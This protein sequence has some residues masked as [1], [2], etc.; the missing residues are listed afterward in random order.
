V[1]SSP[2]QGQENPPC[3][4]CE[5]MDLLADDP[6]LQIELV[7]TALYEMYARRGGTRGKDGRY[8]CKCGRHAVNPE[9]GEVTCP[10]C[11]NRM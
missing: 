7:E 11:L 6:D 10:E 5:F 1:S 4:V 9:A 2:S 3:Q 8:W